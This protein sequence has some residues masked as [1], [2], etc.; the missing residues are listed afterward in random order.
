M[1]SVGGFLCMF[2]GK[3]G[4]FTIIGTAPEFPILPLSEFHLSMALWTD[5]LN[6]ITAW[7]FTN[8]KFTLFLQSTATPFTG[9]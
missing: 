9:C 1:L 3:N 6:V 8:T 2:T 4:I 5:R 7:V